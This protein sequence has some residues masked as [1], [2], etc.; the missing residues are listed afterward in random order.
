M[1]DPYSCH[2]PSRRTHQH[3]SRDNV[4]RNRG[5]PPA[6]APPPCRRKRE[7]SR[8]ARRDCPPVRPPLAAAPG[9]CP[10]KSGRGGPA[11]QPHGP[12]RP[13]APPQI[14]RAPEGESPRT[15]ISSLSLSSK[16]HH[17]AAVAL[18]ARHLFDP[19]PYP[20]IHFYLVP[21]MKPPRLASSITGHTNRTFMICR[22]R[23][24]QR[25]QITINQ[26]RCMGSGFH[27]DEDI[28]LVARPG[29]VQGADDIRADGA[30]RQGRHQQL[31]AQPQPIS[32]RAAK[33]RD[34]TALC[35]FGVGGG[36]AIR[37]HRP[38]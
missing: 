11:M 36:S 33:G 18:G 34:R 16:P 8:R 10:C 17:A 25:L 26:R 27:D 21:L 6:A 19:C 20:T 9:G 24:A 38:P 3:R 29:A 5:F 7:P 32:L 1:R 4:T 35:H 14:S 12:R 31:E 22:W 37:T 2:P 28:A 30:A 13:A 15:D 23:R